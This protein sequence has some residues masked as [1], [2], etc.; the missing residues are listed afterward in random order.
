MTQVLDGLEK[1]LSSGVVVSSYSYDRE[2]GSVTVTFE[3]K[4]FNDTAR[5]I[6]NFKKST[7]FSDALL[8]NVARAEKGVTSDMSMT[9]KVD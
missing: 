6:L 7:Y 2:S 1:D 9:V 4:N 5:Q 8:G 3:S